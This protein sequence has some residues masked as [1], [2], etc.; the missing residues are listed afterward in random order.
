MAAFGNSYGMEKEQVTIFR[1]GA[2]VGRASPLH[3][4]EEPK[5]PLV[6]HLVGRGLQH[7]VL[8][9]WDLNGDGVIS[10]EELIAAADEH[11]KLRKL[12]KGYRMLTWAVAALL[13]LLLVLVASG[14][15]VHH[16]RHAWAHKALYKVPDLLALYKVD[17]VHL[18]KIKFVSVCVPNTKSMVFFKVEAMERT[19]SS[20]ILQ[21]SLGREIVITEDTVTYLKDGEIVQAHTPLSVSQG[22]HLLTTSPPP[23]PPAA[24]QPGCCIIRPCCG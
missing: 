24:G 1:N 19:Y 4:V 13:F 18:H 7:L 15:L 9:G 12:V 5:Q 2:I 23:P 14:P 21:S 17:P 3:D 20:L 6:T 22:R 10:E 8:Q 16:R 11:M